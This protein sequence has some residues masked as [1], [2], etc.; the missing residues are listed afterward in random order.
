MLVLFSFS[1]RHLKQIAQFWLHCL[2]SGLQV[3]RKQELPE[4]RHSI[5]LSKP[6]LTEEI[7]IDILSEGKRKGHAFESVSG[8]KG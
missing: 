6:S 4:E 5:Y 8:K 7:I 3:N 2:R 1:L